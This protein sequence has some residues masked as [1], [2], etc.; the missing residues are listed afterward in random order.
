MTSAHLLPLSI[1]VL[2]TIGGGASLAQSRA[3]RTTAGTTRD[4]GVIPFTIHVS[5]AALTDLKQRLARARFPDELDDAGWTFGTNLTYLKELV[6]YWRD[7]FDWRAQERRLN[8][9]E[10]FKT[11]I[12]GLD[13]HF[14]H[15]RSKLPNAFPLIMTHGWPGSFAEFAKVI[16]PLTDPVAHGGRPEDA[17]DVVVPSIP[18]Y[19][20]SDKPRRLGYGRDG[21]AAIMAKL[22]AR[23]GYT[24]YGAQGGD[25]GSGIST[26]MAL[27]DAAHV[28]GLHLN[29]CAGD[30]P[31]PSNPTAGV[32]P[33][34]IAR[35]R[36]RE[37]FWTDEERGY[38]HIQGTRPQTLGYALNDSPVGLAA[39]I[40]EKFRTWCDCDGNPEARFTKDEL[41]TNIMLYWVTATPTSAA[42]FYYEGRH[43]P[44]ATNRRVQIPTACAAFPKEIRF[45]PRRW[46][47]MRYNL[48]RFTVMPHGGHFAALEQPDL[49]V[50]DVRAFFRDLRS[51]ASTPR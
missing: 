24:R 21:T 31:D 28:A 47:E 36:E 11:N 35:M 44:G 18:G 12:D 9:F 8:Q 43:N 40:V 51:P 29:L 1:G 5:D 23:L 7:K 34:E 19:G 46:L 39:W 14:I 50:E 42:R 32:P 6:A 37:A 45:T 38:S 33:D 16:G 4:A 22:M 30:P 48:T 2:L 20:F 17:F 13:I 10:Q 3:P 27:D 49:L 15:R 41:L 26:Q 25:L